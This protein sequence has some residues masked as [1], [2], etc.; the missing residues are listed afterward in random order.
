MSRTGWCIVTAGILAVT[1]VTVAGVRCCVLGDEVRL[2]VGPG[3]WKVTLVVQGI[4]QGSRLTT[5]APLDNA[6]QHVSHEEFS[7][8]QFTARG[9]DTTHPERRSVAWTRLPGTADGPFRLHSE[10]QVTVNTTHPSGNP[11]ESHGPYAPPQPG[12]HL[13]LDGLTDAEKQKLSDQ[14]RQV[15]IG[16]EAAADVTEALYRFVDGRIHTEPTVD[17]HPISPLEC[18]RDQAGDSSA[19]ARLL[20]A[21]L[22]CRGIQA[23]LVTGLTLAHGPEQRFHYWAEAWVQER[24]LSLCPCFHHFGKVPTTYLVF[25]YGDHL[26]QR[27]QRRAR[28]LTHA[29]LVE[30]ISAADPDG[31]QAPPLRRFFRA[32]SLFRLP[33][34]EQKLVEFL[35]LLPVAAL[36]I[37]VF[38]NLIGLN[39]FGTFAPALVGLAFRDLRSLPGLLVFAS[40]LLVGWIMRRVLDRYHLLQV[41]RIALMLTLIVVVLTGCIVAANCCD[42]AATRFISLFPMI[43]LTGMVERFWTLETEDGTVASFR[44]LFNTLFICGVIALVVGTPFVVRQLFRFPET[45]GLLMACQLLIGRYT[46][47]RVLELLRFRDFLK[48]P[49][50]AL[51]EA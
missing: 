14:A 25:T 35:L 12:E 34:A 15:T 19:K 23:R 43:I 44:T 30:R 31:G 22:R 11:R 37:C 47:Y 38:R 17:D 33:P 46:G 24:W 1:A 6:R 50:A 42:V 3:S 28:E 39:S 20:V 49:S 18:L 10:F 32:V 8:P 51:R 36:V 26:V 4:S 45:L 29:F 5:S 27:P 16:H 7:S 41:P 9:P 48:V 40:I 21:L 13:E 2:P